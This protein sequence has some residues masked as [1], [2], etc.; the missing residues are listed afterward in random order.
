MGG[1]ATRSADIASSQIPGSDTIKSY[2]NIRPLPTQLLDH[3]SVC[4]EEQLFTQALSLLKNSLTSGNGTSTTACVPPHKHLTLIATLVTHPSMTT[5]TQSQDKHTSADQALG[6]LKHLHSVV[7]SDASGLGKLLQ[8]GENGALRAKRAR[9][10]Q[11]DIV[12]DGEDDKPDA[13]RSKYA[14][15]ESLFRNVDDFWAMFGWAMN[16]SVAHK[17]RWYRWNLWLDFVLDV[18]ERDLISRH[19]QTKQDPAFPIQAQR[20]TMEASLIARYLAPYSGESRNNKRRLMRAIL[21]DGK[22]KSLNEF[23]E[24]WRNETRPPKKKE[25]PKTG[26]KRKLDIEHD[27]YGDYFDSESDSNS[28]GANG[29]RSSRTTTRHSSARPSLAGA[30][31][32]SSDLSS[33]ARSTGKASQS[34]SAASATSVESYGGIDS[35]Q[36]RQRLLALLARFCSL[37]PSY[38][39]DTEDLFDL[40]TEFLKPLPLPVFSA[41]ILPSKRYLDTHLQASLDQMLLRPLLASS[42]PVYDDNSLTQE[43]FESHFAPYAANSTSVVEN[44]RVGLLV[45]DLMRL[46]WTEGGLQNSNSLRKAVE[47]GIK[48][49]KDKAVWDGRRK[50]E[51]KAREE[52][53]AM[54]MLESSGERMIWMLD[55]IQ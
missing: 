28:P 45:E 1:V 42:A 46:L 24:I 20:T 13:L 9:F 7:G 2:R 40:F 37:H 3:C 17:P 5:R 48:A 31:D 54:L 18:L 15:K 39:Y 34:T 8:F 51:I 38:F 26:R 47:A 35:I 27:M 4:L 12:S 21:A 43:D 36:I 22:L 49:R 29:L 44:A 53:E 32:S 52:V 33:P 10:R 30:E 50:T 55:M 19:A 11:S 14:N 16:C 23:P 6:Y 41:L 25:E